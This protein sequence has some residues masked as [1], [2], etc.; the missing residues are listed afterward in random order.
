[1]IRIPSKIIHCI[2]FL[3]NYDGLGIIQRWFSFAFRQNC[4]Q[5]TSL[6]FDSDESLTY[7]AADGFEIRV[8]LLL[9]KLPSRVIEPHLPGASGF[10]KLET[11]SVY[12]ASHYHAVWQ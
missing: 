5:F 9:D 10:M 8:C 7:K 11:L 2:N 4:L 3:S 6:A 12:V 1:M